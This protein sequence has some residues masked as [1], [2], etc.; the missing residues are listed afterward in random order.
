ME[1]FIFF[2][3]DGTLVPFGK[4]M[5]PATLASLQKARAAGH[6]ILL[7]T[8]RSVSEIDPTLFDF[9]FDGGVYSAGA[10]LEYQGQVL[11][12][13]FM[14]ANEVSSIFSYARDNDID[15]M[16]Q[17]PEGSFLTPQF[18]KT[19]RNLFISSF[20]R[21]LVISSIREEAILHQRADITKFIIHSHK[22]TVNEIRADLSSAFVV[23]DNTMG[24]PKDYTA[25]VVQKGINKATGIACFERLLHLDHS[26]TIA[27]G[28]GIN[29]KEM[30]AYASI[31]VA[32]GNGADEVK[33]LAD[34]VTGSVD[35][36]GVKSA[37]E[38][39]QVI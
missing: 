37:L 32:M 39:C 4:K 24:V 10:Y 8:G 9:E 31:G 18:K 12:Q 20:G 5:S 6:K 16:I 38:F 15:L 17:T 23:V 21:P 2:D 3:V 35:S 25:E 7:A 28:D 22:K 29:D 34:F 14:G 30:I 26:Q 36:D 13:S 11:N 1:K 33:K 19:L 27:M